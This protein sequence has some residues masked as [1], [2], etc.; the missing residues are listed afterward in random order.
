MATRDEYIKRMKGQL[1]EW[2]AEI[3]EIE[4][5]FDAASDATKAKLE[6]HLA[7]VREA[8]DATISKL[9][10]IKDAGEASWDKVEGEAEHLW[11][12]FK[13]SVNYFKSQL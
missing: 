4:A 13:Q 10:E 2:N 7:K 11:K 9:A 5:R 3:D 12:T 6:P 1:D 8:R